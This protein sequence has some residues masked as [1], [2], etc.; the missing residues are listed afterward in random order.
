M[1]VYHQRWL[2]CSR[3][4]IKRFLVIDDKACMN[5]FEILLNLFYVLDLP[6]LLF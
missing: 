1:H 2:P 6:N 3:A 4:Q 5:L